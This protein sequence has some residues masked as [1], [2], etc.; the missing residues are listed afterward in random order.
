MV[1]SQNIIIFHEERKMELID[2]IGQLEAL[3]SS[4]SF[5][6]QESPNNP[7]LDFYLQTL[8]L[9][10]LSTLKSLVDEVIA[11]YERLTEK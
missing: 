5:K 1:K 11:A 9:N 7:R 6:V 10:L 4:V 2:T 3:A 8:F